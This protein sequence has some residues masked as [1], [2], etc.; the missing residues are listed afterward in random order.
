MNNKQRAAARR[1]AVFK[2]VQRQY[3]ERFR[4]I[5]ARDISKHVGFAHTVCHYHLVCLCGSGELVRELKTSG[6]WGFAPNNLNKTSKRA[7]AW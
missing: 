2:E 3:A 1:L 4:G 7:F 6:T 5:T